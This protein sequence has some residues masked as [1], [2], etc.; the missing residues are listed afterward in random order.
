MIK[1]TLKT[2]VDNGVSCLVELSWVK[3]Y[4]PIVKFKN[5]GVIL[6]E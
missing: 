3:F 5:R 4:D 1:L 6:I 2:E